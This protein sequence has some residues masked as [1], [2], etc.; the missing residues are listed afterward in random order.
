MV[1]VVVMVYYAWL[2]WILCALSGVCHLPDLTWCCAL[3]VNVCRAAELHD[4]Y[5][6]INDCERKMEKTETKKRKAKKSCFDAHRCC[7]VR[8]L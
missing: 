1:V 4:F 5:N 8:L 2:A 6:S 7:Y 3:I